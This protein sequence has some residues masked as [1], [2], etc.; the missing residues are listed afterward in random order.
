MQKETLED[1]VGNAEKKKLQQKLDKVEIVFSLIRKKIGDTA[2]KESR[3][4][5]ALQKA[6]K[7][8]PL[9]IDLQ[10]V[11]VYGL[12]IGTITYDWN[13]SLDEKQERSYRCY[14]NLQRIEEIA[15]Y[16]TEQEEKYAKTAAQS[17]SPKD[18][19]TTI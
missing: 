11:I 1:K 4:I 12:H 17:L 6:E 13:L 19:K 3:L 8:H 18:L 9:G 5:E 7:E 14:T 15:P 10:Q 16:A 2:F